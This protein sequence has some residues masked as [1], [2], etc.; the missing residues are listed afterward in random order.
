[1][2]GFDAGGPEI[3]KP[4]LVNRSL[5]LN[6]E[7]IRAR[8]E[9]ADPLGRV[10]GCLCEGVE[11]L[12]AEVETIGVGDALIGDA[13]VVEAVEIRRVDQ[14]PAEAIV[15]DTEDGGDGVEF[16]DIGGCG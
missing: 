3:T 14:P 11:A 4:I 12:F 6:Q 1:M 13:V 2:H 9:W 15:V 16:G 5:R 7:K 8:V 10:I